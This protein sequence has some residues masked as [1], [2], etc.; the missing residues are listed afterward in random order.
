MAQCTASECRWQF[1]LRR[2]KRNRVPDVRLARLL[3]DWQQLRSTAPG[4]AIAWASEAN[5][6]PQEGETP[7][8]TVARSY[9]LLRRSS[10]LAFEFH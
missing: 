7:C 8:E 3:C 9:S 1:F 2:A 6:A 10:V 5:S 4:F